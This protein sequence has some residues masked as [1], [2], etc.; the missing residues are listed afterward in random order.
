MLACQNI[1]GL[2]LG[3]CGGR[4]T[5]VPIY[6]LGVFQVLAGQ[7]IPGLSLGMSLDVCG[8]VTGVLTYSLGVCGG[9][10]TGLLIYPLVCFRC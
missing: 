6:T 10:V 9:R 2:S 5:G 4:V 7:N 3:V 8:R 1:P